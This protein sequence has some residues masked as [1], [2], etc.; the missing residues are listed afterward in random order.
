MKKK[1]KLLTGLL[2]LCL[3]L[4]CYF[5]LKEFNRRQE[6]ESQEETET[7]LDLEAENINS[8]SFDLNGETVTFTRE[9]ESWSLAGDETFPV[10]TDALASLLNYF[11]PLQAVRK[12]EDVDSDLSEFGLDTPQNKFEIG[13]DDGKTSTITIGSTNSGTG[14]DYVMLNEDSDVIY[15]VSSNLRNAISDE[16][17]DYALSDEVPTFTSEK[18]ESITLEDSENE[19]CLYKKDN[20][21]YVSEINE[22]QDSAENGSPAEDENVQSVTSD[23][24]SLDYNSYVEHNCT[25]LSAYGLDQPARLTIVTASD[26]ETT[27]IILYIG[28]TDSAGNYYVQLEGSTQVHTIASANLDDILNASADSLIKTEEETETEETETEE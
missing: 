2:L 8:F 21:W 7:I 11:S 14:D 25:D 18:I 23:A 15:T 16:L 28:D 13:L 20:E 19:Y 4:L 3:L 12:L 26:D 17:Y 27:T 5:A 24:V 1:K 10:D 6:E 9:D 22:G